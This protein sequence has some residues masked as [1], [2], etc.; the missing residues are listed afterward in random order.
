[1]EQYWVFAFSAA[2]PQQVPNPSKQPGK[3]VI[4]GRDSYATKPLVVPAL[5]PTGPQPDAT[6]ALR[7]PQR[8]LSTLMYRS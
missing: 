5:D 7:W 3:V 4:A 2:L 6:A 8:P 1:V